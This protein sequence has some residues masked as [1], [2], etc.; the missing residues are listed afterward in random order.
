MINHTLY[1][2]CYCITESYLW[3]ILV[4]LFF[5]FKIIFLFSC[6]FLKGSFH[7]L[8]EVV[9]SVLASPWSYAGTEEFHLL[10]L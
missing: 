9:N 2:D 5:Q 1:H 8:L 3:S 6:C 4:I 10:I 7:F